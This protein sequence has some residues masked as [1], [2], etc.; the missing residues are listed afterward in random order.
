MFEFIQIILG[1]FVGVFLL[2][3]GYVALDIWLRGDEY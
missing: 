1:V 3:T 2:F